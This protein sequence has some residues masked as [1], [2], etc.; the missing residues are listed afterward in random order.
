MPYIVKANLEQ[1]IR[2]CSDEGRT[3]KS[4]ADEL[5]CSKERV[6]QLFRKWNLPVPQATRR[7]FKVT[8]QVA[9]G[10]AKWGAAFGNPELKKDTVYQRM[11]IKFSALK[12]KARERNI[13]FDLSFG[14]LEIPSHCPVLGIE[15][16]YFN[17]HRAEDSPSFDKIIP[18][19]GYVKGNV[20][21][22][23][24]R[25]NRIKNDGNAE[26]HK[27]IAQWLT[28]MEESALKGSIKS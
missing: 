20:V 18:S 1:F 23:S 24:W 2:Q 7:K 21:I 27:Q 12:N 22:T 15:L 16:N 8:K 11:R 14:D 28:N 9:D 13:P 4:I 26:E 19:L 3:Y 25:A 17:A 6:R 5:N 10:I